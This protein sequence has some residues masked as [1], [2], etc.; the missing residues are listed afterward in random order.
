MTRPWNIDSRISLILSCKFLQAGYGFIIILLVRKLR[1]QHWLRSLLIRGR[2]VL[3]THVHLIPKP[4]CFFFATLSSALELTLLEK[5]DVAQATETSW[6][7]EA[8]KT[9]LHGCLSWTVIPL[10]SYGSMGVK[11]DPAWER[12]KEKKGTI[13]LQARQDTKTY[14]GS[15]EVCSKSGYVLSFGK[16]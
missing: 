9:I 3:P 15:A 1:P 13:W 11:S 14:W 6:V 5:W 8:H 16:N 10:S 4:I 12:E 2:A 7:S